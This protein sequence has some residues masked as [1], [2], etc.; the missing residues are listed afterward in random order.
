MLRKFAGGIV[1]V[2]LAVSNA[3][4]AILVPGDT[5]PGAVAPVFT[6]SESAPNSTFASWTRFNDF[7]GGPAT[8]SP[9]GYGP[10]TSPR[11]QSSFFGSGGPSSLTFNSFGAIVSSGNAYGGSFAPVP[12]ESLFIT[13]ATAIV[14]SGTEGGDFTRI[15][16]QWDTLGSELDYGS[17]LLSLSTATDGTIAPDF[18]IETGRSTLGGAFGG[19]GVS[20]LALWDLPTSQ[21]AF[22]VD[23]TA[24][25]VNLSLDN[26][27]VDSFVQSTPFASPTAIP[28]PGT[29]VALG[30]LLMTAVIWR[31]RKGASATKVTRHP[32]TAF[33][34]VE[35]LVVIAIIG[36][37]IGLLLPGVQA[38]REAARRMSCSN[39]L[40]QL[41]LAMHHYNQMH[42][43]LPP[44]VLGVRGENDRQGL[45]VN[46]AGLSG[47]VALLPFH[48]NAELYQ[49]FDLNKGSWSPENEQAI[50]KTPPVHLCP[51]MSL[52]D[53]G[54][55]PQGHSSYA[56]STG[57]KKYRNQIHNG[58]VVDSMNVFR[59]DRIIAGIDPNRSWLAPTNVDDISNADGTT[60]TLLAGEYG[61]Q[62]RDQALVP[63]PWPVSGG[64]FAAQWAVSYPYH[65]TASVF[66][67][68][69]ARHISLLD[70]N[71]FESFRG[72]HPGGVQFVLSDGSVRLLNESVDQLILQL[73]ANRA[74]GETINQDPW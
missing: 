13:D 20:Y 57:S 64:E 60:H 48:E 53:S 61:M 46:I 39:N 63:F 34:L 17:I 5:V 25:S 62:F 7:P 38:A 30:G 52:P 27:R 47:W 36:I 44:T 70:F 18:A 49:E 71:S 21:D 51:S 73:L 8:G 16:A 2:L 9:G 28:E 31:R 43:S 45:P 14:R 72:P 23:F 41:G 66:G 33:T 50:K 68:F 15:V 22:R 56:V 42:R 4:A 67:K 3:P 26:F 10:G 1:A 74:D 6:W 40:K 58:A 12:D 24:S 55:T 65:S 32:R 54:T 59:G 35:L 37:L 11:S 19:I 29:L 69:N